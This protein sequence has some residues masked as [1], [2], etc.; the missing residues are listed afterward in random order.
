MELIA[1]ALH[2]S[3]TI[4]DFLHATSLYGVLWPALREWLEEQGGVDTMWSA[5]AWELERASC[6]GGDGGTASH[7][8]MVQAPVSVDAV[9]SLSLF[10][11]KPLPA[12]PQHALLKDHGSGGAATYVLQRTLGDLIPAVFPAMQPKGRMSAVALAH[13]ISLLCCSSAPAAES[14]GKE[15]L[16]PLHLPALR[17]WP[18]LIGAARHQISLPVQDSEER[19]N[20]QVWAHDEG[21]WGILARMHDGARCACGEG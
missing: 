14:G 8:S 20:I 1:A 11:T 5:L 15:Y 2:A 9:L 4:V 19:E 21:T 16:E 12:Q 3:I 10:Y 18:Y 13:R 17:A 6:S 7:M